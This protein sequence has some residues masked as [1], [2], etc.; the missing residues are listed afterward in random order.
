MLL[1]ESEA[2]VV[3]EWVQRAVSVAQERALESLGRSVE[4]QQQEGVAGGDGGCC[5]G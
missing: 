2:A 1:Q 5:W 3:L 4:V